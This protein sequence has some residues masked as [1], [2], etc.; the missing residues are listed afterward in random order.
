MKSSINRF[1]VVPILIVGVA[2]LVAGCRAMKSEKEEKSEATRVSLSQLSSPARATVQRVTSGGK[3]D[4]IDKE[5]EHGKV[6]YDVEATVGGK[7]VEYSIADSDGAVLGTETSIEF[8]ELPQPV[9]L[10][11]EKYFGT[12]TGL[13][14]MKGDEEG[15]TH[16]EVEGKKNGKT[17]EVTF[18]PS[19]KRTE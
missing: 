17:A 4:K 16:Y 13:K 8:A 1:V 11:A 3:V 7:H 9:R 19:G 18:D 14:A 2:G 5:I 12:S 10:A 15:K 6:V